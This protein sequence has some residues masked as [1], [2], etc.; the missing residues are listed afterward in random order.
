MQLSQGKGIYRVDLAEFG[1]LCVWR[2]RES[3]RIVT[4][5][6]IP[7]DTVELCVSRCSDTPVW[8]GMKLPKS[9]V[10]IHQG[11]RTYR[12][13]LPPGGVTYGV[14]VSTSACLRMDL[15]PQELLTRSKSLRQAR[16]FAPETSL[17]RVIRV[18]EVLLHPAS[19]AVPIV[20]SQDA[21]VSCLRKFVD[22]CFSFKSVGEPLVN[23]GL[24]HDATDLISERM[25]DATVKDLLDALGTTRRS[26]ERAFQQHLGVTPY[27]YILADRLHRARQM[28]KQNERS[29]LDVCLRCGFGHASRFAEKYTRQFGELPSETKKRYHRDQAKEEG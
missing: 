20:F 24:V 1:D 19:S 9:S 22:E 12:S 25:H 6:T 4:D 21:A 14:V 26:L 29:V 13:V 28:L 3:Q 10:T 27:Q 11:G 7:P 16:A 23:G 5:F 18:L 17:D 8:C 2:Y 15:I